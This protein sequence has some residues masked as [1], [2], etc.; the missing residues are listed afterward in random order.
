MTAIKKNVDIANCFT[1]S[2]LVAVP[3]S[4]PEGHP[5]GLRG[6]VTDDSYQSRSTPDVAGGGS[7]HERIPHGFAQEQKGRITVHFDLR[8]AKRRCGSR[9]ME[10]ALIRHTKW[11]RWGDS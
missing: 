11:H 6:G 8:I 3:P 1:R 7:R 10:L 2:V 9:M 5:V 4:K